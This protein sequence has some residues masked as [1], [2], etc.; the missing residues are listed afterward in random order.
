MIRQFL[1]LSIFWGLSAVPA[2]SQLNPFSTAVTVNGIGISNY[3]IDQRERLL[4]SINTIGDIDKKA[5]DD[6]ISERLY[7][8]EAN[9]L[10]LDVSQTEIENG[11]VEFAAR[12]ALQPED[13]LNEIAQ[14]GVSRDSFYAFIRAGVAWRKVIG[15]R[16]NSAVGGLNINDVEQ[17]LAFETPPTFTSI[18]LSE[19]ALSLR[20]SAAE[21]SR[22]IAT[23]IFETV[24]TLE[25]FADVARSLSIAE[26]Q[27]DGGAI[28]WIQLDQLPNNLRPAIQVAEIGTVTQPV[29]SS[30]A[31]YVFFKEDQRVE[32]GT[33]LP[34]VTDYAVLQVGPNA[35][36]TAQQRATEIQSNLRSCF[37]L[38][39]VSREFPQ[40]SF[41]TETTN[42]DEGSGP[43]SRELARL[44]SRES[45]ILPIVGSDAVELL[46]LCS[47]RASLPEEQ[48]EAVLNLKRNQQLEKYASILLQNLRANAFI[49]RN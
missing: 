44:D 31:T 20:P 15:F 7:L 10:G 28:G 9:R 46:M 38:R 22:Q 37:D 12:A 5:L 30:G 34:E 24:T 18:R 16:Y 43:Y 21:R 49:T 23:Q 48:Q 33:L 14:F 11:V 4:L 36:A 3:E 6:L 32:T 40:D 27:N 13:F 8:D 1:L 41:R 42:A 29:E 47:R 17:Y 35:S 19:I 26:S 2:F 45:A 39:S 25:E